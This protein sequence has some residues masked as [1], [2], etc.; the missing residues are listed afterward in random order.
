MLEKE[1]VDYKNIGA[2]VMNCNPFT[3]GHRYL[4]EQAKK[5]AEH[6]IYTSFSMVNTSTGRL[7]SFHPNLQNIPVLL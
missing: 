1:R 3:K 6:R 5:S 4:I 7:A 2:I